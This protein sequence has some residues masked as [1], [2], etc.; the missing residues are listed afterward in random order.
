LRV[1]AETTRVLAVESEDDGFPAPGL[2]SFD[3]RRY[4]D[5][6]LGPFD[7]YLDKP[8]I[9]VLLASALVTTFFVLGLRRSK[10]V[11]RGLQNVAESVYDFVDLQ[12][13]RETIGP[14]DGPRFSPYLTVLFAFVLTCNIFA[15]IPGLQLP[16]T[17][18]IAI[19]AVL[20]VLSWLIFNYIGI[21]ANGAGGYFKE[22][23]FPP[24][25][26]KPV[27]LLLT[28][29]ELVSTLLVR[30]FTLAVRLFANMFA[31][32]TLI[33]VFSLGAEYLL[34]RPPYAF[35]VVSL[36]MT[37]I[38]TAF[39]VVVQLLQ[40]YIFTILTA[41]YIGGAMEHGHDDTHAEPAPALGG[42]PAHAA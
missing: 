25:V 27:Y 6:D 3:F 28:P 30:P 13:A 37:F 5:I 9:Q 34:E 15:I 4:V 19:P 42:Q 29:I 12:I 41:A 22:L 20:A 23:A 16:A 33:L 35:G 21:K 39:E 17:S 7:L 26:P 18:K 40:A 10:L 36:L 31:G 8:M 14:R 11:P 32:H 2:N 38:L 1:L 24:G